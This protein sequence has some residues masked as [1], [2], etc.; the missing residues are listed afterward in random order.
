MKICIIGNI[1][2]DVYL[3]IDARTEW[4]EKDKNGVDWLDIG[5]DSGQHHFF[6]R[7]SMLGGAAI[8]L[9]VLSKLGLDTQVITSDLHLEPDGLVATTPAGAYR[10]ILVA[11][12]AVSYLVPTLPTDTDFVAPEGFVDYLYIDRS[13]HLTR[14][15]AAK[16]SAYLDFSSN[17][18]LVV[19]LQNTADRTLAELA[20]R[21]ELVMVENRTS[22]SATGAP[23]ST[24][25]SSAATPRATKATNTPD[26]LPP[27]LSSIATDRLIYL[28]EHSLSWRGASHRLSVSRSDM[29]THLSIFSVASA[30]ILGAHLLGRTPEE[31]LS[32]AVAN[33]EN[34]RLNSVLPLEE[35]EK[36][37]KNTPAAPSPMSDLELIAASLVYQGRGILAADESSGN[38]H[39]KFAKLSIP[40]TYENRRDY[41]NLFFTTPHL[42]RYLT[43]IIL[44]DETTKQFADNGQNFI[45]YLTAQRIVPGI[46]V[47]QGLKNFDNSLETYTQGLEGLPQR[48][49]EYHSRGLRFAKWR[50]AFEIRTSTAGEIL[51]PT[52]YA[53]R[54]NCRILAEYAKACQNAGLVPIVEP[55]VVYDGYY[56]QAQC[57]QITTRVLTTLFSSLSDAGVNLKACLLKTNMVMAGKQYHEQSTPDAVGRTTAKVLKKCVPEDLAGVVFLSG[58][59]T[60]DQA[61]A[62]LA[63]IEKNGPYPWPVT[64]SFARALQE[65]ALKAWKGN[66]KNVSTAQSAFLDRLKANTE[67]LLAVDF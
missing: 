57:E 60:P 35:L 63:A 18:K 11:N 49:A 46:K 43:G 13:A 6:S 14:E 51:T 56:S 58:G 17:T 42:E 3:D 40:D 36:I 29:L 55:E 4:L 48:L 24:P 20:E 27:E 30:T 16:I 21:A 23:S 47:D 50:A 28:S 66:N 8:S 15:A 59:Q 12:D 33:V 61:T 7:T 39:Q 32:L 10:Y 67:S 9:E 5:F 31:A 52:E 1:L 45:D 64:F 2:K 22:V 34:S 41:R 38:I 53:I 44:F 62:N 25:V 54:E 26:I 19:Y 37:V 65:P